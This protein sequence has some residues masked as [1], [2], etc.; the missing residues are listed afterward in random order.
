MMERMK[1][2][3]HLALDGHSLRLF[4]A[5]LDEGSVTAAA[6]RLDLTQ[7]AVS[8]ALQKLRSVVGDPLFVKSGR[9]IVATA[10]ALTLA[11]RARTLIDGLEEFARAPEFDPSR[12]ELSLTIGANDFQAE[13][14]LPQ[15]HRRLAAVA[16]R[17]ELRIIPSGTPSPDL[18]RD[19]RCDLVISPLPPEGT[20]IVQRKMFED[21]YVCFYDPSCRPPPLTEADY[22]AA[23]HATVVHADSD[24]LEFDKRLD[25]LGIARDVVIRVPGFGGVPNF[26]RGTDMLA[27]L[28]GLLSRNLMQGFGAVPVPVLPVAPES[29][30]T[31]PMFMAWHQR[32]QLSPA[33]LW[34]R[35][36]VLAVA[37]DV[38][39]A[40]VLE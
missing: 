15:V 13:L 38:S 4:L 28:P 33:H 22:L 35:S 36:V 1:K 5:V 17:V 7:S 32:D 11:S 23:R 26:L 30:A 20:D 34:L 8:H 40:G 39:R 24:R 25:D 16:R 21:R 31:L 12:A 29:L 14:L 18:L 37:Q 2:I 3:D 27:S 6:Q 19:K 10:H 9:G